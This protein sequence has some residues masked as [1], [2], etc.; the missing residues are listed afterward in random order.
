MPYLKLLEENIQGVNGLFISN[1]ALDV[2]EMIECLIC[3]YIPD[4]ETKMNRLITI[5]EHSESFRKLSALWT[6]ET[7]TLLQSQCLILEKKNLRSC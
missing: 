7:P 1:E 2:K 3:R 4:V 5:L 6:K